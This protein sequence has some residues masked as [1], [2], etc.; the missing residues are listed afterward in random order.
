MV[1]IFIL[2][3]ILCLASGINRLR[4][5]KLDTNLISDSGLAK[6]V[7]RVGDRDAGRAIAILSKSTKLEVKAD[8]GNLT[9]KV[10]SSESDAR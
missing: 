9:K 7:S 4:W 8:V 6:A 3:M 10:N 5:L 1:I 2:W